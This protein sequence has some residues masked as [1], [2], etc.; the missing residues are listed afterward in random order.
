MV[1]ILSDINVI[2]YGTKH[3]R[4]VIFRSTLMNVKKLAEICTVNGFK[5][6]LKKHF[7]YSYTFEPD[8]IYY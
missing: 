3:S 6:A 1:K 8:F 2:N 4:Q 5:E 7:L